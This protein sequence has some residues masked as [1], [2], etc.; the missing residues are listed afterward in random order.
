MNLPRFVRSPPVKLYALVTA[1]LLGCTTPPEQMPSL[2]A[3]H[4]ESTEVY[5]S[6]DGGCQEQ[7]I[8]RIDATTSSI[9]V[10]AY[11][12][13]SHPIAAALVRAKSRGVD[14]RVLLDKSNKGATKSEISTLLSGR[15]PTWLDKK[16]SIA[17]NKVMVFDGL[18]V[19]TGSYNY[20]AAGENSNAEN[21]LFVRDDTLAQ[22][23][24]K[25]WEKHRGHS[26]SP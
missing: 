14:V 10:Q 1:F 20:T 19:E 15:V 11:S 13:T 5:F 12:F 17:H 24:T 18:I 6:P 26:E 7:V 3:S 4:L 21:C 23:Y 2:P 8:A 9:R 22:S 16:H 25:N